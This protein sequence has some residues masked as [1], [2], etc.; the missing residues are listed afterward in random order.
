MYIIKYEV[1]V[2]SRDTKF[3]RLLW[4]GAGVAGL[5]A[6][7]REGRGVLMVGRTYS[8]SLTSLEPCQRPPYSRPRPITTTG[9]L[10]AI[11]MEPTRDGV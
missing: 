2:V 11:L 3:L 7:R 1:I 6:L 5:P 9:S 8:T 4:R 10:N